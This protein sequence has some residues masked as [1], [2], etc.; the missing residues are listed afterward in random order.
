MNNQIIFIKQ[1]I[2]FGDQV[3]QFIN[4]FVQAKLSYTNGFTI[5]LRN[6]I[7]KGN[8]IENGTLKFIGINK[9]RFNPINF[10]IDYHKDGY[11]GVACFYFNG[12]N[13]HFSLYSNNSAID[14][15]LIAKQFNGG[16][17]KGAAGFT[18]SQEEFNQLVIDKFHL[19]LQ[20]CTH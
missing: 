16:G 11:D 1:Q 19:H 17:H 12:A 5:Y 15:S 20:I 14:C 18:L 4:I 9:E 13:Y 8:V 6:D 2:L 3:T 10:G 7:I